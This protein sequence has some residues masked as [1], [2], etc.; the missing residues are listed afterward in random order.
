MH[1]LVS[2]VG[3]VLSGKENYLEWSRKIKH[4]L[5]FND[6]WDGICDGDTSPT[7]PTIDKELAIWMNKDK[8][9]YALIV[10]SVSE[11]VSHHIKSIKYS[12]GALKKLKYLYDS[13]SKLELIQL[14]LK[15]FNLELKDNDPMALASKIKSIMHDIDVTGVKIDISLMAFIKALYPTYSHYL[16]SLQASGQ[17]KS[18]N[19]DSLVEKIVEHEK[20]FR[21]KTVHP[22]GETMC[23]AQKGKNQSHDSSRGEGSKRGHGKKYFRGRGVGIIKVRDLI[24]T[25]FIVERMDMMQ[26]HVGSHGRRSKKSRNKKGR[27]R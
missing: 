17:L 11:E 16:E 4:T 5:I 10:A 24:F 9:A 27:K 14:L 18:L 25:V 7:K 8:K 1:S 22:T 26:R 12:W 13:H 19:F 3:V 2:I 23:L 20:D 21:K 15:L 6:L